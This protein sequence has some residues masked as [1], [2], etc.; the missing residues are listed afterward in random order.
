MTTE[1][2][3]VKSAYWSGI[4]KKRQ[5]SG[6]SAYKW[7]EQNGVSEKTYYNWERLLNGCSKMVPP[8]RASYTKEFK[9]D[10][11]RKFNNRGAKTAT[12][13]AQE[14]GV[15]SS[16]LY[17]WNREAKKMDCKPSAEPIEQP[18]TGFINVRVNGVALRIPMDTPLDMIETILKALR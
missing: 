6:L 5:E 14:L 7:C 15:N 17:R 2:F 4:I 10:A 8:T 9:E 3:R 18:S 12:D 11:V 13:V 1:E 16:L